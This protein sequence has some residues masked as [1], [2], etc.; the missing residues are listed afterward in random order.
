M[1]E[2]R[3]FLLIGITVVLLYMLGLSWPE[4]RGN[5]APLMLV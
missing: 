3:D 2:T 1:N 4:V 5:V